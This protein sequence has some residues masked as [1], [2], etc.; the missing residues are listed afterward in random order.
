MSFDMVCA[1]AKKQKRRLP[2]Y[3]SW[4]TTSLNTLWESPRRKARSQCVLYS[5]LH[6]EV[7]I[8]RRI[9]LIC[10]CTPKRIMR[11]KFTHISPNGN[12]FSHRLFS[13][14]LNNIYLQQRQATTGATAYLKVHQGMVLNFSLSSRRRSYRACRYSLAN[15]SWLLRVAIAAT[16]FRF[17]LVWG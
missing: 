6:S 11:R 13:I 12:G 10:K 4:F 8:Q 15:S 7:G 16:E 2:S 3:A 9:E 17:A 14:M 5:S 1:L